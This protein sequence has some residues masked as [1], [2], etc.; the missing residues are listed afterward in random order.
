MLVAV[1]VCEPSSNIV[2]RGRQISTDE[3]GLRYL[4]G[5]K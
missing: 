3:T 2:H 5:L 4:G 1:C